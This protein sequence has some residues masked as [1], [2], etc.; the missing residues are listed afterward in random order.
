MAGDE[1]LGRDERRLPYFGAPPSRTPRLVVE[2][3][4]LRGKRVVLSRPHGFVYDVRAVSEL[5]TN[6]DGHLCVEVVTEEE[7]FRW[8]FTQE[9]P[10]IVT[11]PARLVWVE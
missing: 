3:P 7:Y 2:E 9:Q 10:T 11:Y 8:M 5:W 4:T 6:D 1:A